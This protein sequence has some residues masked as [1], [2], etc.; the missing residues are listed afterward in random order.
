MRSQPSC[1]TIVAPCYNESAGIRKFYETLVNALTQTGIS[2][3]IIF[4]DDGSQDNT[5]NQLTALAAD[6]DRLSIVALSRN[7]GHQA[8]LTAGLDRANGDVVITMDSDLQ[9]PPA[10]IPELIQWYQ[11][12]ADIVYAARRRAQQDVGPLKQLASSAYYVLLKRMT[13]IEVIPG[14]A[15]FRLMS[16]EAVQALRRMREH[17]RYIRG[18]VPWLGFNSAVVYYDQPE[19]YAGRPTYTWRKSFQMA[20]H[21]L[22]SFTTIPLDL[23]TILGVVVVTLS[24]VYFIW[25]IVVWALGYSV[26]GWASV[27]G[28]TLLIGGVQLITTGIM[29]Q[30]IGMIFE[31]TKG[32]PLYVT[33]HPSTLPARTPADAAQHADE[34]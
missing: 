25:V 15:D 22:F 9:H 17:H 31:Q 20:R 6:D 13:N 8:A 1:L 23:I 27:V 10:L 16:A 11:N 3:D 34:A 24:A 33:K 26:A 4:V 28:V 19:R 14:A 18:M 29:A 2:F 32:R 12:G 21:G 5:L 30:Y 7:Y